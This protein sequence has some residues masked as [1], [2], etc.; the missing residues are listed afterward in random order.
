MNPSVLAVGCM[1]A[2]SDSDVTVYP[3][4]SHRLSC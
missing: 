3:V 4:L 2:D 1:I